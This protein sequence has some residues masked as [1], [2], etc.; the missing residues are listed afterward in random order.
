MESKHIK[1][2]SRPTRYIFVTGGVISGVGKGITAASIGAILKGKGFKVSIQKCDPYLN[3]D[4]GLLN[5][6]EHGECFVT[7]DG[8]ETDLDLGH[9]ER[10]LDEETTR[11]SITLSGKLFKELIE[12]ERA[13]G[14]HGQTVQLVPHLTDA[15]HEKISRSAREQNSDIH[16]VEI[17]GTVGDYEG[18]SFVEA[19]RTFANLVGRENCLYL[20]VVYVPFLATSREFK[21]KPAQNA[22]KDLRG[23][24]IIPDIVAVR[25]EKSMGK[26]I[27]DK[28]AK[29]AG[30]SPDAVILLPDAASVYE[31]P[32]QVAKSAVVKILNQF[33]RDD[34]TPDLTAWEKFYAR[35]SEKFAQTVRVGLV[36]KYVA[37][38]DTYISVTEALKAAAWTEGVNLEIIWLNAEK[39]SD[40][41]F[42]N[43]D[44][45]LV[46]GG[47]GTRGL[48]GK[49]AAADFCLANDKPYLGLCLGL[50]MAVVAAARRGG[51]KHATT[52][53]VDPNSR[54][55]VVYIMADQKGRENTG[56]TMRLG[57]YPAVLAKDS[58]TAKIYGSRNI[59]ERH[60]HRYEVNLAFREN[61]EKGGLAI[62]G[63]S[64]DGKLVEFV[65]SPTAKFF[66]ATQG[67][68]EFRSRP[69][70]PHPLFRAFV[71]ATRV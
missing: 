30:I 54:E 8:A 18:L 7:R 24:G 40:A 36:A 15:I 43:V 55:N 2:T 65:E 47:F 41:D 11:N 34:S 12:K 64:P 56:G 31:V 69:V 33:V 6:A 29:F 70:R 60:R 4:A 49:I 51:L 28:I 16:I 45:I 25:A 10:F 48:D 17:G 61:I 9:Y 37:N 62:S 57:D 44:G 53:E 13:G 58:L 38:E 46:P 42:A 63:T 39:V 19:I 35:T 5:P 14:F 66:V 50:Q 26:E 68:P 59:V 3:V 71:L 21:T 20:H 32:L 1:Q 27:G 52:E 22:L 23:F 67:H